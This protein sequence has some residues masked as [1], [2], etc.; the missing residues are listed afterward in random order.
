[1]GMI[2]LLSLTVRFSIAA[3]LEMS[4]KVTEGVLPAA[5]DLPD[6]R[7]YYLTDPMGSMG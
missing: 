7:I 2:D 6:R 4:G 3:A 1:M 5:A